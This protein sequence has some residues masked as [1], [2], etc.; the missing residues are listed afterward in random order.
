MEFW[1]NNLENKNKIHWVGF[2][3]LTM[4]KNLG[5]IGFKDLELF[6]QA[7]L[8][9]QAWRILSEPNSL[10]SRF[11]KIRYFVNSLFLESVIGRR[12]SYVWRSILFRRELLIKGIKRLIGN[13]E[14][15]LVWIDKWLYDGVARRPVGRHFLM[16]IELRVADLIDPLF[17]NWHD[18][19]LRDLFHHSDVR[20][21]KAMRPKID[22]RGSYCLDMNWLIDWRTRRK[23]QRPVSFHL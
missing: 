16:N 6:N 8:T 21:I 4:S 19:L 20:I 2:D 23:L 9:K 3:K 17:G 1:W 5:G 7:L 10:F 18:R 15:T 13:G 11:Y 22:S 14:E 12:P